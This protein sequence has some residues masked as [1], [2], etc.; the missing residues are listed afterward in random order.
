MK[1]LLLIFLCSTSVVS[2][3]DVEQDKLVHFTAGALI[4]GLSYGI[5]Y[6]HT[7][8]KP[9]A[10]LYSTACA[11]LAGTIKEVYDAKYRKNDFGVEDL[12]ITTFGGLIASS[13]ITISINN[14]EKRKQLEK[15][16]KLKKEEQLEKE[17]PYNAPITGVGFVPEE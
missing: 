14:K 15:I 7:K 1:T 13:F 4:S 3:I 2:Q 9:K 6:K 8:S 5:I 10:I 12:A 17:I 11:F 16:E